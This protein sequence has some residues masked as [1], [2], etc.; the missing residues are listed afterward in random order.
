MH[1]PDVKRMLLELRA[2]TFAMR[3][4][5]YSLGAYADQLEHITDTNQK[6][7]LAQLVYVLLPIAKG[8]CTEKASYNSALAVQV[9]G[10]MGYVE[11]TAQRPVLAASAELLQ[12]AVEQA[13]FDWALI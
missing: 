12:R 10:G 1:H 11:E 6:E 2:T 13:S 5:C 7:Q 9:F 3:A 8:W 4:L